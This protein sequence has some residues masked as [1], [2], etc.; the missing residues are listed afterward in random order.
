[1]A[2]PQKAAAPKPKRLEF[3]DN[4]RSMSIMF[5]VTMHAAVTYSNFGSWYY[6]EPPPTDKLTLLFFGMY[7]TFLQ[8]WFMG[9][10]FLLAGYFVP[11]S[12]DSKGAGKF[13]ADRAYRLG[14]PSLIYV[15]LVHPF[16][17]WILLPA[18][19]SPSLGAFMSHWVRYFTSLKFLGGTGPMWFAVALLIFSVVYAAIRGVTGEPAP[20]RG[21]AGVPGH[22][23]AL[24]LVLAISICAFAIR[25]VQ[26]LGTNVY[27]MQLGFFAQ[28]VILFAVGILA[29]RRDWLLQLPYRIGMQ[30]FLVAWFLGIPLWFAVMIGGGALNV[31]GLAAFSG[32]WHWQSAAFAV[33]ES[34]VCVGTCLGL[35]VLFRERL[36]FKNE[37]GRF[38]S[39]NAF[40]VYVFHPPVLIAI[41]LL[42]HPWQGPSIARFAIASVLAVTATFLA[43]EFVFRRIPLLRYVL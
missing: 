34:L 35:I 33:W 38:L 8:A 19:R 36:N 15:V 11:L 17:V 40:A 10:L 1:M 32:G 30:W 43:S 18:Y 27:N 24:L 9:F 39:D 14:I 31:N 26:P 2:A 13:L 21:N 12:F 25:L 6:M 16:I 41:T 22:G 37:A 42:M 4:L 20:A 7:Q 5:V 23:S 3:V 29:R 28:Y